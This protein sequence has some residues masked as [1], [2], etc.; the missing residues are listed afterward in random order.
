MEE[1]KINVHCEHGVY[2]QI[3][4]PKCLYVI[5]FSPSDRKITKSDCLTDTKSEEL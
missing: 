2:Y 4:P 1:D 5:S 3:R